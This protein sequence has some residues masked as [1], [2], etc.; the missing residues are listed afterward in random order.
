M[1]DR[2]VRLAEDSLAFFATFVGTL[3]ICHMVDRIAFGLAMN[4]AI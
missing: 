1:T 4:G 2:L 3:L